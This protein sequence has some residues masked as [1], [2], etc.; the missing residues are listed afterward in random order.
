MTAILV[1]SQ[2][3][4][5]ECWSDYHPLGRCFRGRAVPDRRSC[6]DWSAPFVFV[7]VGTLM[8]DGPS[9]ATTDLLEASL[10]F[11]AVLAAP[12]T[13][14][15]GPIF[16]MLGGS[17]LTGAAFALICGGLGLALME[18]FVVAVNILDRHGYSADYISL[19]L[20]GGFVG[21]VTGG[22]FR[23]VMKSI[24]TRLLPADTT[25]ARK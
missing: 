4:W 12:G 23:A 5:H 17:R 20:A 18:A 1:S 7:A 22:F 24:E 3:P 25:N 2:T 19:P 13:L 9:L 16:Y 8:K 10:G 6:F 21:L 14:L 15:L 11:A